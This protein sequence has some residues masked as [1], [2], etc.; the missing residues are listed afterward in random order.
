MV[1]NAVEYL[2]ETEIVDSTGAA[3]E[4]DAVI[5]ATGFQPA[6]YLAQ[7]KVVGRGGEELHERWAGE[8]SAYLGIGVPGF[9]NF[10][11]IYGPNTNSPVA[12]F[13]EQQARFAV[14][15]I[16][17]TMLRRRRSIEVRRSAFRWFDAWMQQQDGGKR[18]GQRRTTTSAL[19]AGGWLRSG[20]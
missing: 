13:L 14:R 1:P 4:V 20:R 12:V 8:P 19:K 9:P 18:A 17:W 15:A 5:M 11:M 16:K 7:L 6:N 2:T 10:F 3:R